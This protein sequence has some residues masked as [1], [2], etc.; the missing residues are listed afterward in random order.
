MTSRL[1]GVNTWRAVAKISSRGGVGE[2]GGG[3]S[4]TLETAQT[5]HLVWGRAS[6]YRTKN[7][8]D[9]LAPGI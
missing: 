8:D 4:P 1:Q 5:S 6:K 3:Q 9:K 2:R 7:S